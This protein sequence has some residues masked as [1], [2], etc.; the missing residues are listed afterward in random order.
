MGTLKSM[1]MNCAPR[2]SICSRT[3]GRVS[4][5]RTAAPMQRAWAAA[6]SP[7]TPPPTTS[8]RHGGTRP[9]AY[10]F[11]T[12]EEPWKIGRGLDDGAIAGDVCHGAQSVKRLRSTNAGAFGKT[13][14]AKKNAPQEAWQKF[15]RPESCRDVLEILILYRL[16][17]AT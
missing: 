16:A 1:V 11:R 14:I 9:A 8:T 5:A 15:S 3:A 7:A 6:A 2:L 4:K 10:L 17:V 13:I 12:R